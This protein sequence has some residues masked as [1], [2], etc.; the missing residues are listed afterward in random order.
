MNEWSLGALTVAGV[1]GLSLLYAVGRMTQLR[2]TFPFSRRSLR[3]C[4][5]DWSRQTGLPHAYSSWLP[6]VPV[7]VPEPGRAKPL[8]G[9]LDSLGWEAR[10]VK[11]VLVI[12]RRGEENDLD[13]VFEQSLDDIALEEV[14]NCH[15]VIGDDE[16]A[17][18]H[19]FLTV[20]ELKPQRIIL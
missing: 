9:L 7:T 16:D 2:P 11:G 12:A 14:D 18:F 19:K 15:A 4:L 20:V 8:R 5:A 3:E 10:T 13:S 6:D 17:F 1:V